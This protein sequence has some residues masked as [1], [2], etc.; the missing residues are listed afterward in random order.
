MYGEV[1]IIKKEAKLVDGEWVA[2]DIIEILDPVRNRI[3]YSWWI[4]MYNISDNGANRTDIGTMAVTQAKYTGAAVAKLETSEGWIIG[5]V[6]NTGTYTAKSG[7]DDA[8]FELQTTINPP[9]VTTRNIRT[10]A[11]GA[12]AQAAYAIIPLSSPCPQTTTEILQINYKV[13][14][15]Y[16]TLLAEGSAGE[17]AFTES[18]REVAL[19]TASN[20]LDNGLYLFREVRLLDYDSN[21]GWGRGVGEKVSGALTGT[22][23]GNFEI[24]YTESSGLDLEGAQGLKRFNVIAQFGESNSPTLNDWQTGFTLKAIGIGSDGTTIQIADVSKGVVSSVQNTYGRSADVGAQRAPFLDNNIIAT[25]AASLNIQDI[26]DWVSSNVDGTRMPYLYRVTMETG[27]LVGAATYKVRRKKLCRWHA[28]DSQWI[29]LGM[30]MPTMGGYDVSHQ[31]GRS[32]QMD[33]NTDDVR[34]GQQ[35]SHGAG[36]INATN[37]G[38]T[39]LAQR[40]VY[41]E[42]LTFNYTG[43]TMNDVG[44]YYVNIDANSTPALNVTEVL[45]VGVDGTDILVADAASGLHYLQRDM[46]DWDN[47]T[48]TI[49]QLSPPGITD[50]TS[51]RG[52]TLKGRPG[53]FGAIDKIRVIRGGSNYAATDT[54]TITGTNGS[55]A[56]AEVA[57]VDGDGAITS[58]R[59]TNGG[60]GY[61]EDS[62]Q[63]YVSSGNGV[64]AKL[65]PVIQAAQGD[66][67]ALF[68]DVTDGFMYLAH[69][70]RITTDATSLNFDTTGDTITRS[71]G[72]SDFVAEGFRPNQKLYIKDAED[73]GN[74][75][76]FTITAVTTTVI[77]V[78]ENLTTNA[79]DTTA[80]LRGINWEIMTEVITDDSST[81]NFNGAGDPDT[82]TGNGTSFITQGFREGMKINISSAEDVGNDGSYTIADVTATVIT[83]DQADSL[84]TNTD[85]TT[86]VIRTET[87]FTITNFTSGSPG[88]TQ[89]IGLVIDPF[90]ADDR[91]IMLTPDTKTPNDG[92]AQQ[93]QGGFNWWSYAGSSDGTTDSLR[94]ASTTN[95]A[96]MGGEQVGPLCVQTVE[97]DNSWITSEANDP[98]D[99]LWYDWRATGSTSYTNGEGN[100]GRQL[101]L[102]NKDVPPVDTIVT[103]GTTNRLIR[104]TTDRTEGATITNYDTILADVV[105]GPTT[106]ETYTGPNSSYALAYMG[107][108]IMLGFQTS[109]TT[110][111][112]GGWNIWTHNADG[113]LAEEDNMPYGFWEEFGWDG[114]RWVLGNASAKT[115]HSA[116]TFVG[117][118]LN[119]NH[120]AGTIVGTFT[121]TDWAGDGFGVGDHITIASSENGGE[122]DGVY[123]IEQL[124]GTTL[125]VTPDRPLLATNAADTTATVTGSTALID[126]LSIEF[127]DNTGADTFVVNEY[128][129]THVYDGI[130]K[131][132]ATRAVFDVDFFMA[133]T[134]SGTNFSSATVPAAPGAVTDIPFAVVNHGNFTTQGYFYY[135]PGMAA[136][137]SNSSGVQTGMGEHMMSGDF[138]MR[139]RVAGASE[140]CDCY[141]GIIP[142]S[143]VISG[144]TAQNPTDA[145]ENM[146]VLYDKTGFP[147][148]NQYDIEFRTTGQ[149][150]VQSTYNADRVML[151]TAQ[152]YLNFDGGANNGSFEAGSGHAISD[153]ITMDDGSTITVGNVSAGQITEW[154]IT[155]QATASSGRTER[156]ITSDATTFTFTD[157]NPDTIQNTNGTNFETLGFSVGMK[158]WI[159]NAT[160]AANDGNYTITAVSTDTITVDGALTGSSDTSATISTAITQA[161][162]DGSG[163]DFAF[164]L[165]TNNEVDSDLANDL[166][167]FDRTG[168]AS[169]NITVGI[170][171]VEIYAFS[172]TQNLDVAPMAHWSSSAGGGATVY[173]WVLD[174]TDNRRT[175][176]V[177]NGTTT[178]ASSNNFWMLPYL[179]ADRGIT[180]NCNGV[181]MTLLT[182][183]FTSPATGEVNILMGSGRLWFNDAQAGQTITGTWITTKK[184]NLT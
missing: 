82:I 119:F 103:V 86:A 28:N 141:V 136:G 139:F 165:G 143:E 44:G 40:Y 168:A 73:A 97:T 74:T 31:L 135:E 60:S 104:T 154:S 11:F 153:V 51:C 157:A 77:T 55:S 175:V 138:Q 163:V 123:T 20:S 182:D 15:D 113:R 79:A 134:D 166:F 75:G 23:A 127:D 173:N 41:P 87:D 91:F 64:G 117:T 45:Q 155:T 110:S 126:G 67:W 146:K 8:F 57:T 66:W 24:Y 156:I 34:H 81:Y 4:Q 38:G 93:T 5:S 90:H 178:G 6:A 58:V 137:G 35:H 172:T 149:G 92:V 46:G 131:D 76:I 71:G 37:G 78:S 47:S 49:T 174:Y 96:V 52:V 167:Y 147:L 62:I 56:T 142:W 89:F 29:A 36:T 72:V 125:T 48:L 18:L 106:T 181:A 152:D 133:A 59:V 124:S 10:I 158:I 107:K 9:A 145:D 54:V 16:T 112:P 1:T 19:P 63:L 85:D 88:P 27:G 3:C 108:G 2:G 184:I 101:A 114:T 65:E 21:T 42:V 171:G 129:D 128:Y 53:D 120:T 33:T 43:I 17:R 159:R 50:A 25:S 32:L 69:A 176:T 111:G 39:L 140:L 151:N 162:T 102:K 14:I 144:D 164:T 160:N 30:S 170:N 161:S 61:F 84:T 183:G 179:Q 7:M 150:A 118:N 13:I 180:V 148:L 22:Q 83:L 177:G 122:N 132:N 12:S 115:T 26:G 121:G 95:N 99:G 94:T 109:A 98:V 70:T 100:R 116:A 105:I 130:L 80:V 68:D 169:G